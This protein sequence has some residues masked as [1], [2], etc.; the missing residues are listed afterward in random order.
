MCRGIPT[1]PLRPT[2]GHTVGFISRSSG[3]Y[4]M[5]GSIFDTPTYSHLLRAD[6]SR[7]IFY[8]GCDL[9]VLHGELHRRG[10]PPGHVFV[11]QSDETLYLPH[12]GA[13]IYSSADVSSHLL[14]VISHLLTVI[15]HLLTVIS[16][17]LTWRYSTRNC[18]DAAH[19][20]FTSFSACL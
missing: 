7:A 3:R 1:R 16:H 6:V 10:A 15:S 13:A 2:I 5:S 17:L 12:P 18:G 20:P 19:R 4:P 9:A 14:T 8:P 11:N